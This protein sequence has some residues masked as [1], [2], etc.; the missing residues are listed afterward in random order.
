MKRILILTLVLSVVAGLTSTAKEAVRP[1]ND[2]AASN[3]IVLTA[4]AVTVFEIQED[5]SSAYLVCLE[6]AKQKSHQ[7][8]ET[9]TH[10]SITSLLPEPITLA[11][12]GLCGFTLR[13]RK[14]M[15]R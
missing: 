14:A 11:M 8:A 6:N 13:R 5:S 10:A 9:E 7:K 15:S 2:N 1:Q 4:S 12:L 3:D